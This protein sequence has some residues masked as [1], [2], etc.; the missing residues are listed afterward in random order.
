[1]CV[2]KLSFIFYKFMH[3]VRIQRFFPGFIH[4]F[5]LAILACN[6][7]K[8]ERQRLFIKWKLKKWTNQQI[9]IAKAF[10]H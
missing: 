1:M 3:S 6:A 2:I 8:R 9:L 4:S 10:A 5:F 7:N